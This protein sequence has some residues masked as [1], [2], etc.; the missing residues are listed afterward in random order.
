MSKATYT[1]STAIIPIAKLSLV[2]GGVVRNLISAVGKQARVTENT[3]S[4]LCIPMGA[5]GIPIQNLISDHIHWR[6]PTLCLEM[7]ILARVF[8]SGA[9][10]GT[11]TIPEI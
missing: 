9:M 2:L 5:C 4:T 11:V 6:A 1:L 3:S 7:I 8:P 10:I